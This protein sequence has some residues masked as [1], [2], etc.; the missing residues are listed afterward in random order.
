MNKK[1]REAVKKAKGK[2]NEANCAIQCIEKYLT[3]AFFKDDDTPHISACTGEEIILEYHRREL[4]INQVIDIM[5][6]TG[7]ITPNDFI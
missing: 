4:D 5:E 1:L 3:F 6:N 2:L 7:Y